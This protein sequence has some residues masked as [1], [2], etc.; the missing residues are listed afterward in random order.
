MRSHFFSSRIVLNIVIAAAA[1]AM[2]AHAQTASTG[3]IAGVVS[4]PKH[5]VI[6]GV[7]V[8][9][10]SE[11]TGE[12]RSVP[13]QA[14][15][16][17]SVPLLPPG[18]YRVE[19]RKGGF[20]NVLN[21]GLNVTVG[22]T[23]RLDIQ[24]ELSAVQEEVTVGAN[25]QALDTQ[26]ASLGR[27]TGEQT[28]QELP[29]AARNFTQI[30]GLNPGVAQDINNATDI[31][32]GSGGMSTFSVG[33]GSVKDN[34]FQMDGLGT[35]DIQNSGQFS[36]GVAIPNPDTIQEFR[37]LTNQ[38]DASY[39][40]DGGAQI[41]VV[42]K[43]GTN[44]L[45]GSLFE[46]LRNDDLNANDFFFNRQGSRRPVLK[47]NQ[48]GGTIG[49]KIIKDKLFFFGSYQGT[50]QRNGVT[51]G[52]CATSFVMPPLTDNR[53]A[54]A[55]GA[56]FAGQ[57]G[58]LGGA[59]VAANGSNISPQAL[60]LLNLKF[61]NGQYVIPSP[62]KIDPTQ[63]FATQ[64]SSVYSAPCPF[65]EDQYL[66]NVDYV[67]STKSRLAAKLFVANSNLTNTF[68]STNLGGPTA[69]GWPVV[70]PNK[71]VIA[72][73]THT[74]VFTSSL[75]NELQIG[76]HRQ[77]VGFEQVEPI[78]YSDFGV[79]APSYDNNIPEIFINGALT[80][81]GNG[82]SLLNYQNNYDLQDTLSWTHGNHTI[83][84]GGGAEY[85]QNNNLGFHYLAGV[86]FLSFPDMLIGGPGNVF[87][88]VDLPGQ[89]D[90]AFRVWDA[91]AWVQ[92]DIKVSSRLTVNIG[93]RFERLGN[94]ADA[95]GRN[96]DFDYTMANPNPPSTGTLAG[97]TVP[98]NY[99]GTVP[100]GVTKV[101]NDSGLRDYGLNTWNPKL[102]FA[103]QLPHT[104]R[105]VLRGGY[106]MSHQRTTG[107]PFIQLLTAP[108]F[109]VTNILSGGLAANLTFANPFPPAVTLPVYQPYS[110]TTLE[111][112]TIIDQNY[113]P[114]TFQHYSLGV[115]T[116]LMSD[117]VLDISYV[118]GRDTHLLQTR[119]INQAILASPTNPIRGVT[120]DT[121]A[122]IQ[123]RVPYQG[124]TSSG[125][126]DIE[127][128]GAGWYNALYA[129]LN[130]QFRH[131][132][133]LQA[134]YT[135]SRLLSTDLSSAAG[136]NGGST[137]GDQNSPQQRYGPDSFIRDQRF[138]VSGVYTLPGPTGKTLLGETLGGWQV[139]AVTTFQTG[140]RLTI[141][142][143][144][145]NNV[146]GITSDRGQIAAG[147]TYPQLLT[148][149]DIENNLNSYFNKS[150]V[151]AYPVIGSD[152][153]GT[154][155]GNIG[156]GTERGPGQKNID[157]SLV[158]NFPMAW[159]GEHSSLQFRTEFFN[160]FNWVNFAN[161]SASQ[162]SSAFGHILA[163]SVNPRV[164]QFALKFR[165]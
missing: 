57:S 94:L 69:P 58:L 112:L 89:F 54:A 156:V 158:K 122:N 90:R 4:D 120:T 103:W 12:T 134:A 95:L 36:G 2:T 92:D 93:L 133:Q 83:R 143:T 150:C 144:N 1:V 119:S 99:R 138:V 30:V 149:G 40:R 68:I 104:D 49:G 159:P 118:G 101:G 7:Q 47:Q 145:A 23:A 157:F 71:F 148:S 6:P 13:T 70:N 163:T 27:T 121:V 59:K 108:P 17:Y 147:C 46:F 39:G 20:R 14:N 3:A 113:R 50:R 110:P 74:Y 32:R 19:F 65:T 135:F 53:S 66:A 18:S 146:F 29:L 35:N 132:L 34:N 87:E 129:N 164:V 15:G 115:Q 25:A 52:S 28:I 84:V 5:A 9:V 64:G 161:P 81:G 45:H 33:G 97:F 123:T 153:K 85:T 131:G 60:Q 165:F 72:S 117:L 88:T 162:T 51:A 155:F 63:P 102:G 142:G 106:G 137:T 152:N 91:N 61:P 78:S 80:L 37:V 125:L 55:L 79:N 31:G 44:Q 109:A 10:T 139:G 56:L 100:A 22:Q 96:S 128:A 16:A 42:T 62:Q 127:N 86:L 114:P 130:K 160:V 48:F 38:Y 140:D 24:L 136:A 82:Q 116:K 43:S 98:A 111:A 67:M 75:I 107:Q 124:F 105:F 76:Y 11:T 26:A 73:L 21:T 151:G 8:T 77:Q 141:T 126:T 154:T 41:N